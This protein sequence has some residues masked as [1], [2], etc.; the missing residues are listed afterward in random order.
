MTQTEGSENGV[1]ELG[2]LLV[3]DITEEKLPEVFGTLKDS[4]LARGAVAIS[5]EFPKHIPLAYTM[6]KTI[7]NKIERFNNGYFGWIKFELEGLK[8]AELE[9]SLRLRTDVIRHLLVST[10][11]EN[12][13]ASKRGFGV[14]RRTKDESG[15]ESAAPEMSKEEIDR[16][17]E[18]LVDDKAAA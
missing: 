15:K 4:I 2:F 18:A 11:R 10:V 1:Y 8:V 17:I 6:E 5:E 13:I 16:E 3:P 12:T 14:R 7:N 9:A